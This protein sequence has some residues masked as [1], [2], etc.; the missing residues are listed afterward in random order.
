MRRLTSEEGT[1]KFYSRVF[2]GRKENW[3]EEFKHDGAIRT[4][5]CIRPFPFRWWNEYPAKCVAFF[6]SCVS[7][8]DCFRPLVLIFIIV[9]TGPSLAIIL[10]ITLMMGEFPSLC[11]K[12][13]SRAMYALL[14][15]LAV[16]RARVD[17]WRYRMAGATERIVVVVVI[18]IKHWE[19][20]KFSKF[21]IF[22]AIIVVKFLYLV[23]S[24]AVLG[25][26][27][28]TVR[29]TVENIWELKIGVNSRSCSSSR[30]SRASV[31]SESLTQLAFPTRSRGIVFENLE[32]CQSAGNRILRSGS[33]SIPD[34][35]D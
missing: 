11:T 4:Q 15:I 33:W 10:A 9:S 14:P 12:P 26:A 5:F 16:V 29:G 17:R 24:L 34:C 23:N 3:W 8:I 1:V 7:I 30:D 28:V 20:D 31:S 22:F 25:V 19:L 2:C 21:F 6:S 27:E 35:R 13:L 18:A 32:Y